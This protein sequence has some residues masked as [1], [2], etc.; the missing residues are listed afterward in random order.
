MQRQNANFQQ[1][2]FS[3]AKNRVHPKH[4]SSQLSPL[5]CVTSAVQPGQKLPK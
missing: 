4:V 2:G 5:I 3:P 1:V